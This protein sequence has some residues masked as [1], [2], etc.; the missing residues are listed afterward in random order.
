MGSALSDKDVKKFKELEK[1]CLLLDILIDCEEYEYYDTE[2]LSLRNISVDLLPKIYE[3]FQGITQK[4]KI[5][6]AI[7]KKIKELGAPKDKNDSVSYTNY[8][9]IILTSKYVRRLIK[10]KERSLETKNVKNLFKALTEELLK[11]IPPKSEDKP[12]QNQLRII[13]FN[14]ISA[15]SESNLSIGYAD[16]ALDELNELNAKWNL[17]NKNINEERIRHPYELYALYNKGLTYLHDH[18]NADLAID[19]LSQIT[20]LFDP[21]I[22]NDANKKTKSFKEEYKKTQDLYPICFWFFYIPSKYLIAEAYGDSSAC[23]NLEETVKQALET[24]EEKTMAGEVN[25]SS[26]TSDME[27]TSRVKNYHLS[28][29]A[30]QL[31]FSAIDKRDKKVFDVSLKNTSDNLSWLDNFRN[32]KNIANIIN[33]LMITNRYLVDHPIIKTQLDSAKVSFLLEYAREFKKQSK[34]YLL[35]SFKICN[36]HLKNGY[37][38]DWSDFAC[39]FLECA[40]FVLENIENKELKLKL[41]QDFQSSYA[42]IFREINNE[43]GW[44]ARR[45]E[46]VEN[47]L[48]CQEKL[49]EL[50]KKKKQMRNKYIQYQ[51]ELIKSISSEDSERKFRKRWPEC[52]KEKLVKNFKE[53]MMSFGFEKVSDWWDSRKANNGIRR[54]KEIIDVIDSEYVM[55]T[56]DDLKP[57]ANFIQN[58]MNC[59]YYTKKLRL[60]TEQFYDHLIYQSCRPSL[61]DCYV[62][63]VLRRWQSFTPALAMGSEVGHKGGGYF[64]YKT[65]HKGEVE[66]GLVV[67][68]GFDFLDNFFDEGFSIRD[69]KG[70]LITHSHT[71][72]A[73]DFMAIV[74]LAHEMNQKGKRIFKNNKWKER[75]LILFIAEGCHQNFAMQIMRNKDKFHD[76]I[77]VKLNTPPYG[78]EG[79][80]LEHFKL[81][82]TKA[83]HADQSDHDSVG[84][85]IKNEEGKELIGFTGDTR[86]FN[87]IEDK[88]KRCPVICMNIGGVIDIFKEPEIKLSDLCDKDEKHIR[89]IRKILLRENHLYLPGF[90]LMA[91]KFSRQE[92]KLLILSEL[93]EEMKGGLRTDFAEEISRELTIPVLPEDIGLT[94]ILDPAKVKVFC[95]VCNS[96][97]APNEI[98]PVETAKDNALVYLCEEHYNQLKEGSLLPKVNELEMDAN[99]LRKPLINKRGSFSPQVFRKFRRRKY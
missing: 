24:I 86:W 14:E 39:T 9:K 70:I 94:V 36:D 68:P 64:V 19:T 55:P 4:E 67:D 95:K 17:K 42:K 77:R 41:P 48:V 74:S 79:N 99:E 10:D 81:E 49:R 73:S 59:D 96:A 23:F 12:R 78:G 97:R 20:S 93:C 33:D 69:I 92:Q 61:S 21:P 7:E 25:I 63:T 38:A 89:N 44:I 30:I 82:A 56:P 6:D 85:I 37:G 80:F 57:I 40:I 53:S 50:W 84:Y 16:V 66:E 71:D 98:V 52:E 1:K 65:N 51:I 29:F 47:F 27:L 72:H 75:K 32:I 45:K 76:V 13:F 62:L 31:I 54:L 26:A 15:C 8:F 87:T 11:I 18:K 35:E 90:L 83:N 43:E 88:Y 28:K 34:K 3:D 2:L 58:N 5:K 91:K 46:L 22:L 60:N